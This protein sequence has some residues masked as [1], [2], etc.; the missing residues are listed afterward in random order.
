MAW[1]PKS[2]LER[3]AQGRAAKKGEEPFDAVKARQN[4]ERKLKKEA[5]KRKPTPRVDT[6][7]WGRRMGYAWAEEIDKAYFAPKLIGDIKYNPGGVWG[8][9]FKQEYDKEEQTDPIGDWVDNWL[10]GENDGGTN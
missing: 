1:K 4:R 3:L 10:K 5:I 2:P 8:L 7:A 9:D 6:G